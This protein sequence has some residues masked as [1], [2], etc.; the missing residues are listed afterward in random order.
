MTPRRRLFRKYVIPFVAV[1]C[2]A[3]LANGLLEIWFSYRENTETLTEIQH[4]KALAAAGRIETFVK[5]IERQIGWVMTPAAARGAA[6]IE[7]RRLDFLRLLRQALAITEVAWLDNAGHEQLRVSRL[8]M[9]VVGSGTDFSKDPRFTGA[10][11]YD[12]AT[13]QWKGKVWFGPVYFRKDSE[14]YM[15]VA[16]GSTQGVT[17]AEVNLKLIWDVVS[18]IKVGKRGHAY[19]VDARGQLIA[20]PDISLVLKKTDLSG[21]AQF[22]AARVAAGASSA[23]SKTVIARDVGTDRRV[24]T[25]F[26]TIAPLG[27]TVFVEQPL[28]DA[29]APLWGSVYR[30][31]VLMLLGVVL[32]VVASL[33]LARRMTRPIQILGASAARIGGGDLGHR[34]EIHTGDEL[35]M[36]ADE[37]NTMTARLQES[38]A[39]LE[40]RVEERT[41]ELSESLEQQ[42]A[43]AEILRVI[44][45]SPTDVQPV[46]DAIVEHAGRLAGGI[47]TIALRFEGEQ[48]VLAAHNAPTGEAR[49]Q[50]RR[51]FPIPIATLDAWGRRTLMSG[52]VIQEPD[53]AADPDYP[54]TGREAARIWGYRARLIVPMIREGRPIGVIAVGRPQP[55]SFSDKDVAL[56]QTFADQAVIAIENVRLFTELQTR[57]REVTEA[58][59]RQTATGEI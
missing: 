55:G 36:L 25:A 57:N 18:Q 13:K 12:P 17:T 37:F 56:L 20:H 9:D 30:T 1:V 34:I 58:L 5:E 14:P 2:L 27:W 59:E 11:Q 32:S 16:L 28:A 4:E 6:G 50:V 45:S 51:R 10:R 52:S 22:G 38:H 33:L 24:L 39:T 49:D 53:I 26:T 31:G 47:H 46:F 41:R 15:T 7:P 29:F 48:V 42:T 3:L 23:P 21:S 35:E 19:V 8:A 54:E 40:R 43:T 44:S